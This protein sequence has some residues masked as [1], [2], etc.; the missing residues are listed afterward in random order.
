MTHPVARQRRVA[1]AVASKV[2]QVALAAVT[3]L[4]QVNS[5]QFTR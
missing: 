4:E 1:Q 5:I 2:A 3:A